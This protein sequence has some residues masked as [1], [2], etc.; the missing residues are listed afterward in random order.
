LSDIHDRN[1]LPFN[2]RLRLLR[3]RQPVHFH[4]LHATTLHLIGTNREE[5]TYHY[6]GR[7][8]RLTDVFRMVVD[9][10]LG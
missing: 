6:A 3:R 9:G 5:F 8:F 1:E 4:D 2:Q 7:D 10:T